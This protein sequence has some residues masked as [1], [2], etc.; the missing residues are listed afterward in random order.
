MKKYKIITINGKK[1][2]TSHNCPNH[3]FKICKIDHCKNTGQ[4]KNSCP[5]C[6]NKRYKPICRTHNA[7]TA[8]I[9]KK[10]RSSRKDNCEECNTKKDLTVHHKDFNRYNNNIS[11]YQTLCQE[12]HNKKHE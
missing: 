4:L 11:N 6:G 7:R 2:R 9:Y 12:C 10:M 3:E 1:V 8:A 5:V